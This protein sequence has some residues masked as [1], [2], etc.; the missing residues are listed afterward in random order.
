VFEVKIDQRDVRSGLQRSDLGFFEADWLEDPDL[1]W[2]RDMVR[3]LESTVLQGTTPR[4]G[5][6]LPSFVDEKITRYFTRYYRTPLYR[7]YGLDLY[8]LPH[9]SR[10][11][12]RSRCEELLLDEF[13][14]AFLK[15]K[16]IFVHR[17]LDLEQKQ[18]KLLEEEK[19][20]YVIHQWRSNQIQ[21]IFSQVREALNRCTLHGLNRDFFE[22]LQW[23]AQ[24][25]PDG[26]DRLQDLWLEF[27]SRYHRI[28]ED[29]Q[30]RVDAIEPYEAPLARSQIEIVSRG[31]LW[32]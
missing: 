9:E 11:D 17:F 20:E 28:R 30:K 1:D 4:E 3:R 22:D 27:S 32:K 16:E 18:L 14:R 7:N 31:I 12:F 24:L 29:F 10:D 8:S 13:T 6:E 25:P 23:T 21:E 19:L 15:E 2:T 26:Q 5:V